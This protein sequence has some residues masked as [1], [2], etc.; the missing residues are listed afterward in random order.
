MVTPSNDGSTAGVQGLFLDQTIKT[1]GK[2]T[3]AGVAAQKDLDNAKLAL[4]RAR[5]DLST[6]VRNA[7]F[8]LLVSEETVVPVLAPTASSALWPAT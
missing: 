4:K 3:L 1:A 7:Y 8:A 2:L 5:S 6:Q